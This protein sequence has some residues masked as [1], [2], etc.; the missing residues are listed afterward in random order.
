MTKVK[1]KGKKKTI[2]AISRKLGELMY[3]VM[4]SGTDYEERHFK[5]EADSDKGGMLMSA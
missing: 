4:K 1:G 2:V 3:T 5:A